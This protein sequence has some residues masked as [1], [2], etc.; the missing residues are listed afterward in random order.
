MEATFSWPVCPRPALQLPRRRAARRSTGSPWSCQDP[1]EHANKS[2]MLHRLGMFASQVTAGSAN[3]SSRI[4]SLKECFFASL[5]SLAYT[6]LQTVCYAEDLC[7]QCK[8]HVCSSDIPGAGD[9]LLKR[10]RRGLQG[11]QGDLQGWGCHGHHFAQLGGRRSSSV[12]HGLCH[13][14]CPQLCC[15]G[16]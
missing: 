1:A 14:V 11:R 9:C 15:D 13:K 10:N 5:I 3:I 6:A 8:L 16:Q 12:T 7:E 2:V 4:S